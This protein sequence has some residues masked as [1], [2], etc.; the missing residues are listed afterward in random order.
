MSLWRDEVTGCWKIRINVGGRGGRRI[1]KTLDGR[2]SRKDALRLHDQER[3]ALSSRRIVGF[4]TFGDLATFYLNTHAETLAPRWKATIESS[5][6][7]HILPRFKNLRTGDMVPADLVAYL[8]KREKAGTSPATVNRE[9]SMILGILAHAERN[10]KIDRSPIPTR[11]IPRQ[12]E[13]SKQ[14]VYFAPDEWQRFRHAYEDDEKWNA[15]V[16]KVRWLGPE[17]CNPENGSSRR[18]GGGLKPGSPAAAE[19][20]QQLAEAMTLLEFVLLTG[21]RVGEILDLRWGA[22]DWFSGT[23]SIFQ[24]KVRKAKVLPLTPGM[25]AILKG[26]KKGGPDDHVFRPTLGAEAPLW[27]HKR[28]AHAFAVARDLAGLRKELTPHALRRM[29]RWIS[30]GTSTPSALPG[31]CGGAS[32]GPRSP[33][34][35]TRSTS[36]CGCSSTSTAPERLCSPNGSGSGCSPGPPATRCARCSG[37]SSRP[38]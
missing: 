24:N 38:R 33:S 11:A 18:Y 34:P 12:E 32:P 15:Y 20:R 37:S 35:S 13:E 7:L 16:A 26:L 21:S 29:S 9:R 10:S 28:I 31:S 19:Y 5:F 6:R 17:V 36:S 25:E 3:G 8:K 27:H 30:P 22:V 14:D 1:Q 2:L 4:T 23:V